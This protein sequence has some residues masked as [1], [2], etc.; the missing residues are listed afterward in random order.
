M[1]LSRIIIG[2]QFMIL[3]SLVL[4][5][6]FRVRGDVLWSALGEWYWETS[7]VADVDYPVVVPMLM[8]FAPIAWWS[9]I[10]PVAFGIYVAAR[11]R[12]PLDTS[13]LILSS[14]GTVAF[15]VVLIGVFL[16]YSLPFQYMSEP[17][18]FP[19]DLPSMIAN[20]SLVALSVGMA[21]YAI[22][23]ERAKRSSPTIC[24]KTSN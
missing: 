21:A 8:P 4:G 23:C 24:E 2:I 16:A 3:G 11:L 14:L 18:E 1:K 20:L 17:T 19:F 13:T 6:L 12:R 10:T 7:E 15:S 9:W 5:L 22:I